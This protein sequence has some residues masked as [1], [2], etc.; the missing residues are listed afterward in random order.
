MYISPLNRLSPLGGGLIGGNFSLASA[1]H[2]WNYQN[3][4]VDGTTTTVPD[5][6]SVG[7]M[8]MAN[9]DA[10]SQPTLTADYLEFDGINDFIEYVVADFMSGST[11]GIVHSCIDSVNSDP[12]VV[13][14]SANSAIPTEYLLFNNTG[15]NDNQANLN[16][17]NIKRTTPTIGTGKQ[18]ISFVQDGTSLYIL[19]NG[20]KVLVYTTSTLTTQWFDDLTS[21]QIS[22]GTNKTSSPFFT[23]LRLKYISYGNY[24][25]EANAIIDALKIVNSDL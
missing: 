24:S 19:H 6:G 4:V 25:S 16:G 7:G 23:S 8:P 5:T 11:T 20:V 1:L 17:T 3:T 12:M 10:G 14:S 13:F 22:L 2:Q 21:T 18:V 15:A 9:P